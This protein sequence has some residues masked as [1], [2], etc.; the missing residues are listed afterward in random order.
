MTRRL[1]VAVLS[2]AHTHALSYVHA[3]LQDP[4]IELI[5]TD[6]DG[7]A[8]PD[9][10][11]RGA[12]LAAQLGVTYVDSYDEAFSWGPDAVVVASENARHR[13]LVLR[14]A[15]ADAH[16]LCEKPLATTVA[17]AEAMRGACAAA[18]VLLMVAYPVRFAPEFRDALA[19][20][21]SGR[22]GRVLSITGVN[23][24]KLPQDRAWF[25]DPELA[26]GGALVDHVVHCADL[27]D[28]LLG[29]R[30]AT[31]RAVS[32]RILHA[33]RELAVETGGIVTVQ[34]PSGV[35]ASIDC[36]WSWPMSSPTWG[37][38]TLQIVLELGT[39][40]V[41]PFRRGVAGHDAAGETW[42][43]VGADLDALMLAEFLDAVRTDRTPQPDA[44]V[45]IRTLEIVSAARTSAASSGTP[46]QLA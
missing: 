31:V 7:A 4:D 13:D 38:L 18:G 16:V 46:V 20:I 12:E 10:A 35:I 39:L 37:G 34:Y 3:L 26:G 44:A 8:A 40:T 2:F 30:A 36:S 11:P 1:K 25:T 21:R 27:I 33:D 41:S 9:D 22:L 45:G 43:P 24:G 5:A 42:T 17:D 23:N 32:N 29:E 15:E 14:A 28:E 19:Q 6:P